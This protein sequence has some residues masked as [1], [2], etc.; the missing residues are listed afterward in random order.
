M[1]AK[2][3]HVLNKKLPI[4]LPTTP[5]EFTTNAATVFGSNSAF[6]VYMS[7]TDLSGL[8]TYYIEA[9]NRETGEWFELLDP[10][11][12]DGTLKV[13]KNVPAGTDKFAWSFFEIAQG[14]KIR[15]KIDT[16]GLTGTINNITIIA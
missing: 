15:L 10:T 9:Y 11:D 12:T 4:T 7:T 2:T 13:S 16:T 6:G 5:V 1:Q 14:S 8:L 3:Q